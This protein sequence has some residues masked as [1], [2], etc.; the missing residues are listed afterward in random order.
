[1]PGL[2]APA[3]VWATLD[4]LHVPLPQ[5]TPV[6]APSP[7]VPSLYPRLPPPLPP[8]GLAA[9]RS[10]RPPGLKLSPVPRRG[11]FCTPC[12]PVCLGDAF[13]TPCTPS[14]GSLSCRSGHTSQP[15][16]TVTPL[17]PQRPTP[18]PLLLPPCLGPLTLES[19]LRPSAHH[20]QGLSW[21]RGPPDGSGASRMPQLP[22][23]SGRPACHG[24]LMAQGAPRAHSTWSP[25]CCPW[26]QRFAGL[27]RGPNASRPPCQAVSGLCAQLT[28][29]H[30]SRDVGSA[31]SGRRVLR[32]KCE[33]ARTGLVR[34]TGPAVPG[35]GPPAHPAV[36]K[37][38]SRRRETALT[39]R[40][41]RLFPR[42]T[43]SGCR[44]PCG[45][46]QSG[47]E[48]AGHSAGRYP[49][50]S[51]SVVSARWTVTCPLSDVVV[52]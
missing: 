10:A 46:R 45:T 35:A 49:R 28:Q 48:R 16:F 19:I 21:S 3:G 20:A 1:M 15:A 39:S 50:A 47:G 12:L 52:L 5:R 7:G 22:D 40:Q 24:H 26:H 23:G 13:L 37:P 32:G 8:Q 27:T 4:P 41:S 29:P 30:D 36:T 18:W 51:G 6:P 2:R 9:H 33:Q 25:S 11:S 17:W 42:L 44:G 34:A 31:P 43:F 14:P 38:A